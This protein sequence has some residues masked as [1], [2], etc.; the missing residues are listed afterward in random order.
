KLWIIVMLILTVGSANA[1][2]KKQQIENITTSLDSLN[3]VV[4]HERQLFNT[5]SDSLN[6]ELSQLTKIIDS[7]NLEL[8]QLT[9]LHSK[10]SNALAESN[11]EIKKLEENNSSSKLLISTNTEEISILNDQ[12]VSKE[13]VIASLKNENALKDKEIG[14][15]KNAAIAPK[16]VIPTPV[17]QNEIYFEGTVL[18]E[19]MYDG[20]FFISVEIDKGELAG[21][22]EDLYFRSGMEDF[23]TIDYTGNVNFDGSGECEGKK[24]K[25]VVISS[26][27][28]F[29]N[30][31]TGED[32]LKE[33]YRIKDVNYK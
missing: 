26:T 1:Q 19:S 20:V 24:I 3:Q 17:D 30:Y 21:K 14:E 18:M 29:E 33:I 6:L 2:S 12:I 13:A 27:G 22:S 10:A 31:E 11:K 4:T 8:S 23:N 25:G 7:L 9:N 32:D 16:F 5:T 15:L 28:N